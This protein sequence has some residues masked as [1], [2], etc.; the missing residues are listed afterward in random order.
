M[1]LLLLSAD[2][3]HGQL[4][5]NQNEIGITAFHG[6]HYGS[7]AIFK[8]D[9]ANAEPASLKARYHFGISVQYA[10]N[11]LRARYTNN[12]TPENK[13]R[14]SF[15]GTP[16][17]SFSSQRSDT[18]EQKN[19][20]LRYAELSYLR[21]KS[22]RSFCF[23]YGIGLGGGQ[24]ILISRTYTSDQAVIMADQK[25]L[26]PFFTVSP[27]AEITF[28]VNKRFSIPVNLQWTFIEDLEA[29]RNAEGAQ[30]R[31]SSAPAL[32]IGHWYKWELPTN[33]NYRQVTNSISIR[34]SG[35]HFFGLPPMTK[36]SSP[37]FTI[38]S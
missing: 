31:S 25:S 5:L 18:L 17:F 24:R 27:M 34:R 8:A 38:S 7:A 28:Q 13:V 21:F 32:T 15:N 12:K 6:F 9:Q 4:Q 37:P 36:S 29:L 2:S 23:G 16:K 19:N 1:L 26:Q 3:V 11:G 35:N 22:F 20:A 33:S 30:P 14:L 10:F